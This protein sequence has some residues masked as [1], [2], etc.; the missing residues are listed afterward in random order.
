MGLPTQWQID[1][2]TEHIDAFNNH[3]G[4]DR[5]PEEYLT[6]YAYYKDGEIYERLCHDLG[7]TPRTG[8]N[9]GGTVPDTDTTDTLS[10][11]DRQRL[12]MQL[13]MNMEED[14]SSLTPERRKE[15]LARLGVATTADT[16]EV[17]EVKAQSPDDGDI[18]AM[19][20]QMVQEAVGQAMPQAA[21]QVSLEEVLLAI[22]PRDSDSALMLLEWLQATKRLN[23]VATLSGS[24]GYLW[25]YQEPKGATKEGYTPGGTQGGR[26]VDAALQQA[27]DSGAKPKKTGLC[28]KCWSA[29]ELQ[30]DGTVVTDDGD[31][32]DDA[33]SAV[34]PQGGQHT[35]NA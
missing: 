5:T 16:K 3:T 35:F 12:Q 6:E 33:G 9:Q 22:D 1:H 28:D 10:P 11:G 4:G 15:I 14:G 25:H 8:P 17:E 29:V 18:Q 7:I 23:V 21:P 24:G 30:D 34:C 26:M 32:G 13:D 27:K 19:L 20:R 2:I 31:D